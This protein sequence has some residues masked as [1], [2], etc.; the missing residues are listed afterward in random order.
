[1]IALG[2][3]HSPFDWR[4][5]HDGT[6]TDVIRWN[7]TALDCTVEIRFVTQDGEEI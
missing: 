2:Q 3:K 7:F 5:D 6:A 1:M 4:V